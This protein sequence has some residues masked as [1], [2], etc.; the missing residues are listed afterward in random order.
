MAIVNT[1]VLHAITCT[2]QPW[3]TLDKVN[4]NEGVLELRKRGEKDFLITIGGRVLMTSA[5]HRS[6]DVLANAACDAIA[7][8]SAP[9]VLLGGLGMGFTLKAALLRLPR[10]ATVDVVELNPT[11]VTWCR[12]PLGPLTQHAIT[13]RRVNVITAGVARVVSTAE[14]GTYDAIVVDLYEGPHNNR[15]GDP[16]Y[17]V[18]AIKGAWKALRPDGVFAVWSEEPDRIFEDRMKDGGFELQR[19]RSGSG[20]VHAVYLGVRQNARGK[21]PPAKREA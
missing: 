5:S 14:A 11:V 10:K 15:P 6:E 19:L 3:Q 16:L 4:T 8:V 12:G 18:A 21:R 7:R 1:M 13:D 17:G 9:R 2:V 20:R